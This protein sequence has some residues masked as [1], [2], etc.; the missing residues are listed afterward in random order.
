M[1]A[2]ACAIAGPAA[3]QQ[4]V[5]TNQVTD[6]YQSTHTVPASLLL[7]PMFGVQRGLLTPTMKRQQ[8]R[9]VLALKQ[10]VEQRQAAQDGVLT[11]DD[12]RDIA[13]RY[14]RIVGFGSL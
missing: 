13:R 14:R 1:A 4:T 12:H 7:E 11:I 6:R 5:S 3:A 10:E 8:V 9:Q 2:M